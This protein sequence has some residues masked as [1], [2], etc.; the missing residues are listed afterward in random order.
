LLK[1]AFSPFIFCLKYFAINLKKLLGKFLF[2]ETFEICG[3]CGEDKIFQPK[4]FQKG[5][6]SF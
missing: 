5:E 2:E 6:T 1:N 3:F 4:S